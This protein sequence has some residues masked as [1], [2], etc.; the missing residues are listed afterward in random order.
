M[1][2]IAGSIITSSAFSFIVDEKTSVD[3]YMVGATGAMLFLG[4]LLLPA[5]SIAGIGAGLVAY[6]ALNLGRSARIYRNNYGGLVYVLAEKITG[7]VYSLSPYSTKTPY[8]IDGLAVPAYRRDAVFKVPN[9]V[10][11]I[12]TKDG[13]IEIIGKLSRLVTILDKGGW[14]TEEKAKHRGWDK[15]GHWSEL[16]KALKKYQP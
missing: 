7:K 9:G 13:S 5:T 2:V 8:G 3:P 4:G 11:I 12:I 6:G 10:K 16:F 15:D 14:I 1:E